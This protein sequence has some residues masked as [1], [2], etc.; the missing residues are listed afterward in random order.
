MATVTKRGN[1]Y[2]IRASAGYDLDGKQ[3]VQSMTW[4]PA[5]G[6]TAKQIQKELDRQTVLF[7]ELVK[8]GQHI[9]ADIKFSDFADRWM[10]D[11]ARNQLRPKTVAI[12]AALLPRINAAIG[13]IRLSR[14]QPHH[15]LAFYSNLAETGI[16]KD[17][18]YICSGDLRARIKAAGLTFRQVAAAS[19]ISEQSITSAA[20]GN[21]VSEKTAQGISSALGVPVKK[22]FNAADP[23]KTLSGKTIQSYH[24]LISSIMTTAVQWQV[25]SSNPCSRVKAPKV[26]RKEA[27]SLDEAQAVKLLQCLQNE[28]I[29]YRALF[30]LILYSGMR[31]GEACGLKWDDVDLEHGIVDINKSSLYLP[32]K[33]IYEDDTKNASSR[34]VIRIPAPVTDVLKEYKQY[35]ACEKLRLGDQW[36]E[37]GKVFTRWNG[38]PI[39]PDTVTA[40]FHSFVLRHDLPPVHVHSLRHTCATLLI[41]NGTDIKTVSQRLGHADVTTT[42]NIYIHAIKEADERAAEALADMLAPKA[43]RN[44]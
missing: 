2:R 5:P 22:L 31:R 42:G 21:R 44:A 8:T 18:R 25:I 37:C 29:T 33:G 15:L 39:R 11:Y 34:R 24:R 4:E 36:Q 28:P 20:K 16:R 3:I 7:E 40:W 12:Y 35:Q 27:G 41:Y 32:E 10:N 13:H 38:K 6:M 17:Q 19:N 14:I 30:T 9:S 43:Q 1:T 26:E 23:E